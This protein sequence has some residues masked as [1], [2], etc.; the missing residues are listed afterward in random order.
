MGNLIYTKGSFSG[1][2]T[3]PSASAGNFLRC[4]NFDGRIDEDASS[5]YYFGFLSKK[6]G[7]SALGNTVSSAASR[8]VYLFVPSDYAASDTLRYMQGFN[9]GTLRYLNSSTWTTLASSFLNTCQFCFESYN[10]TAYATN[11]YQAVY[12]WKTS[13]TSAKTLKDKGQTGTLITY[14][15]TFT[16]GSSTVTASGADVTDEISIGDWIQV[17]TGSAWYEV[18]A[19]SYSAPDTT[20]TI[21]ASYAGNN[22]TSAI[23]RKAA[24]S[25][26]RARFIK[27]WRDRMYFASGDGGGLPIVGEVVCDTDTGR[28]LP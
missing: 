22:E 25:T 14:S 3:A 17:S 20:I 13:W 26:I 8:G 16:N 9:D 18:S 2:S 21:T 19:I 6:F 1:I 10:L 27:V 5:T 28:P 4:D 24:G 23:A 11:G 12:K 7:R 15:L